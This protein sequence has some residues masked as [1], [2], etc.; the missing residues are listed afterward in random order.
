MS[1]SS[2][3]REEYLTIIA[4]T[5]GEAMAQ[6]KARGLDAQGYAIAGKIGRHQF[7][8]VGG[9]DLAWWTEHLLGEGLFPAVSAG[10][11]QILISGIDSKFMALPFRELVIAAFTTCTAGSD[12]RDGAFLLQAFNSSRLLAWSE[13]TFFSTPRPVS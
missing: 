8:L 13:R 4:A 12:Q 2:S 6:F 11:A 3:E 9:A 7:S 1:P 10:R 5:A